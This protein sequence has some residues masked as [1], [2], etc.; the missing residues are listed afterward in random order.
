MHHITSLDLPRADMTI[1]Q[2]LDAKL[3]IAY[4]ILSPFY[5]EVT[6]EFLKDSLTIDDCDALWKCV[7]PSSRQGG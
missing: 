1:E 7:S 3:K 6:L 4:A 2:N 5:P